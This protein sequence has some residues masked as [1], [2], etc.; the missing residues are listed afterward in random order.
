MGNPASATRVELEEFDLNPA[1]ILHAK[2]YP[3]D[4]CE[5]DEFEGYDFTEGLDLID[6]LA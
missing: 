3:E 1:D 4:N 6:R 5:N 2:D